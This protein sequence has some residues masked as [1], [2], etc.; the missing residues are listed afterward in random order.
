[1]RSDDPQAIAAALRRVLEGNTEAPDPT[2]LREYSYPP[3]AERMAGAVESAI[4][5]RSA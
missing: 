5:T 3:I 2:R 4:A 1:M